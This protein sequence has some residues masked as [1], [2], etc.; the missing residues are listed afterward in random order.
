MLNFISGNDGAMFTVN[1]SLTGVAVYL[2]HFAIMDLAE[3]DIGR[4]QR[5]I[6]ALQSGR[7]ELLFSA[8]NVV[9]LSGPLG[10]SLDAAKMLLDEVGPHWFPVELD[11]MIVV[12]R[13]KKGMIPAFS[14]VSERLLRDL[15]ANRLRA[16][17]GNIIVVSSDLFR[18]G[19]VLEWIGPQRDSL[20]EGILELDDALIKRIEGYCAS[21]VIDPTWL[22][23]SFPLV[24][25][26]PLKPA[27]FAY[28]NLVRT[29][30]VETAEGRKL[31]KGD[32]LDFCHAVVACGCASAAMLDKHWKRR[33][34]T[35]PQPNRIPPIYYGRDLDKFVDD[36]HTGTVQ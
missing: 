14:C 24:R 28:I 17:S 2:D 6:A 18:L 33:V 34:E 36:L 4:R 3:G 10:A 16:Q 8:S 23:R 20:R 31:K 11:P 19:A 13:E 25:F 26:N 5:F 1:A 9:D 27:T 35:F 32:G 21:F 7:A 12:E 22:D 15:F 29:L 30:V